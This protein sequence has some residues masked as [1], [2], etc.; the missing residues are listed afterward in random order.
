MT[1]II[2]TTHMEIDLEMKGY[3]E[4]EVG[5]G[6][7]INGEPEYSDEDLVEEVCDD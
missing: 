5:T 2:K 7:L 4:F 3:S 1:D 6:N